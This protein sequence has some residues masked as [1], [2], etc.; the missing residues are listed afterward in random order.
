[1]PEPD[2]QVSDLIHRLRRVRVSSITVGIASA[3]LL[4][5]VILGVSWLAVS[6]LDM[7]LGLRSITLKIVTVFLLM[8]ALAVLAHRLVKVFAISH[9]IRTYAARVGSRLKE[10]GLDLLTAL[11]LSEMDNTKLGYSQVLITR[12][13]D[14]ITGNLR[15][16][17][18]RSVSD[19]DR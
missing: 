6:V 9:S 1:M 10:V 4:S 5:L 13:I 8:L 14:D 19:E 12:V 3:V 18:S 11:E 2:V 7:G 17:T 16:S 15:T